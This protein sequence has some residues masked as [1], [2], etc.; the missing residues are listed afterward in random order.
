MLK[1]YNLSEAESL[2]TLKKE[3]HAMASLGHHP[4]IVAPTLFF[5]DDGG[6]EST[7]A[8]YIELPFYDQRDMER[9]LETEDPS[10]D[11]VF[12]ALGDALRGLD[13]MHSR[14]FVP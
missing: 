11:V 2:P 10:E 1:K 8:A 3:L 4:N 12:F 6:S 7:A 9:W 14:G 13:C 5:I